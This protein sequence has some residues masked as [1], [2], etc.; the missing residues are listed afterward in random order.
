MD[1]LQNL[2]TMDKAAT[3]SL[4]GNMGSFADSVFWGLSS[5][6]IWIPV[7]LLFLYFVFRKKTFGR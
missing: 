5:K 3:L 6:L 4:N 7:A 2:D 1:I